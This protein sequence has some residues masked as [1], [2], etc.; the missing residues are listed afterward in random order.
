[1]VKHIAESGLFILPQKGK[2]YCFVCKLFPNHVSSLVLASDG[3]DNWHNSYLIQIHENSEK[4]KNAMLTYPTR[5]QGYTL[6]SK[7]EEQ[8]KAEQQCCCHV[9]E[10]ITA[11]SCTLAERGLPFRGDNGRFGSFNNGDY[12]VF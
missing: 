5:K 12:L 8:I 10:R 4:H 11:V 7:L 1:M 3:F 6:T 9:M 2:I